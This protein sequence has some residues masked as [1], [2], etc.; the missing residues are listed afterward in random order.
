MCA[1][2][3]AG[4]SW[5]R[6]RGALQVCLDCGSGAIELS[7][8]VRDSGTLLRHGKFGPAEWYRNADG[9]TAARDDTSYM[10]ARL[11]ATVRGPVI[12]ARRTD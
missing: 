5:G 4:G 6:L 10:L 7:I 1:D 9:Q 2:H 11:A 12:A 8:F 3:F